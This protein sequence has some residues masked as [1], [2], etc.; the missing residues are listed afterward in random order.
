M[1][2]GIAVPEQREG[3]SA[4]G[5]RLD[6]L[7]IAG[8]HWKILALIGGGMFLDGFDLYLAGG[9]LG[10]LVKSGWSTLQLNALFVMATFVGMAIGAWCSGVLGDRYGR[11][12]TYQANLALFG[13]MSAAAA[14]APN[15][16][17]LIVLR[18]LMGIGLGA[19]IVAGYATLAEFVPAASRGR[20]IA[21]LS[22]IT[23]SALFVSS[24]LGLWVI[25]TFGWRYMF[26]IV[27]AMALVVWALRKSMPESPRWLEAKGRHAEA[28]AILEKIEG[29][30]PI[31]AGRLTPPPIVPAVLETSR[32]SILDVFTGR[33]IKSTLLG[34]LMHVVVG[35]SLYGFIGWLPTFFVK[36]GY[37]VVSSL[38][39]TTLMA[40]GG[41]VGA[42]IGWVLVDS[43]G[44]K[45]AVVGSSIV[46]AV[47]GVAYAFAGDGMALM[48]VGFA[49]V[50][51]VYVMFTVGAQ[52]V[53]ELFPTSHRLRGTGVCATAGRLGTASV[54]FIVIAVFGLAGLPGVLAI[55]VGL[56]LFQAVIM[57][58]FGVE[59]KGRALE[60]IS[61][62]GTKDSA[63]APDK[64]IS[65]RVLS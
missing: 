42:F 56:L 25:P 7:P 54:Q 31:G 15:M 27:G 47:C 55:L 53:P 62:T 39:Y 28:E 43:V 26:G 29:T 6:R 32:G 3:G 14:F 1:D 11:R 48:A 46:A 49:L 44:R 10:A 59:T 58:T 38:Q 23:N 52:F 63:Q 8:F 61:L 12:F 22:V 9:T 16:H 17:V 50:T 57:G 35:F 41:P 20:W 19:E 2:N 40:L 64:I 4:A 51:A 60:A 33:L 34:S 21:L 45:P 13:V 30:I 24:L 37:S 65:K 5:A 36:S 18:F